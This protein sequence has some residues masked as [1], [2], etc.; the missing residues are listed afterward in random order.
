MLIGFEEQIRR[1]ERRNWYREK[2][3]VLFALCQSL[4]KIGEDAPEW[5]W[6]TTKMAAFLRV[7]QGIIS[8]SINVKIWTN[9]DRLPEVP[10]GEGAPK[11]N[12]TKSAAKSARTVIGA[13][14]LAE[15]ASDARVTVVPTGRKKAPEHM[16]STD[17]G[18]LSADEW[19]SATTIHM[20][21]TLGRLWG[22]LPKDSR[23]FLMLDNY[24]H[25]IIASVA[26]IARTTSPAHRK[27]YTDHMQLYLEGIRKLFPQEPI[28][29]NHH[30]ALHL[31]DDLEFLGPVHPWWAMPFERFNG[32]L[33]RIP[34]NSKFSESPHLLRSVEID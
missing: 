20:V 8:A 14:V 33:L 3:S 5:S 10:Q 31:P 13:A 9:Q 32:M 15:I 22:F 25:L 4:W 24:M 34:T 18:K 2:K 1:K 19:R 17:H 23:F 6:A 12:T 21:I 26:A 27:R 30:N 29:I 7:G 16:G 28:T 11:V